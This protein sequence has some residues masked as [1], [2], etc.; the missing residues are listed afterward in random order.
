MHSSLLLSLTTVDAIN[1]G[2]KWRRETL[3]L[4]GTAERYCSKYPISSSL[5][6][7]E[8]WT[9]QIGEM[10]GNLYSLSTCDVPGSVYIISL[11]SH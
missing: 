7:F 4:P 1:S 8:W 3:P 10:R 6:L 9:G 5:D 2:V 11:N